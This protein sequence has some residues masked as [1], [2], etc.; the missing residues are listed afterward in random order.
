MK[1]R[2][3]HA[4][5]RNPDENSDAALD[6]TAIVG[7]GVLVGGVLGYLFYTPCDGARVV[8]GPVAGTTSGIMWGAGAA[9]ALGLVT[10]AFGERSGVYATYAGL[11]IAA[12]AALINHARA[13]G[14]PPP[15]QIPA[16]TQG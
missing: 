2:R 5:R 10:A 8:C 4:R 1:A 12:A 7:L 15:A 13:G 9:G 3:R 11:G 16:S 6:A 14:P